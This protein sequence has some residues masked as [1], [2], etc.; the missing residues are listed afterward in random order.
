MNIDKPIKFVTDHAPAILTAMGVAGL[1]STAVLTARATAQAKD[2]LYVHEPDMYEHEIEKKA[3]LTPREKVELTWHLY[4]PAVII[5]S[6]SA[7]CIIGSHTI[8]V[9]RQAALM[10]L[11]SLADRALTEYQ[12]KAIEVVGEGKAK[13]IEDLYAQHEVD[14]H[15]RQGQE[16]IKTGHGE[17]LCFDIATER[18]FTSSV[19]RI[20]QTVYA[21]QEE[22]R[23]TDTHITVNEFYRRIGLPPVV[24][25]DDTGWTSERIIHCTYTSTLDDNDWPCFVLNYRAGPIRGTRYIERNPS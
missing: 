12:N 5:G 3:L 16:P 25:G 13:A 7:L 2:L 6:V 1:I 22:L 9:K 4:V 21:I 17:H 14:H 24:L 15:P 10:G 20:K 19:E 11:Y 23:T 18:Y 8:N